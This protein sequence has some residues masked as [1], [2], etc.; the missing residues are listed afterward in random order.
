M[1]KKNAVWI[2][3]FVVLAVC[4]AL[5][6]FLLGQG[7]GAVSAQVYLDG[8]LLR[9]IDLSAVAAPYEF[10]VESELGTNTV[11]VENGAIAVISADCPD[12]VC[13]RQGFVSDDAI[14]I[15]C[16]PHRLVIQLTGDAHEN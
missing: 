6:F 2:T 12:Q 11:R 15:V 1:F 13:V 10:D 16:L 8:E 7:V 4:G 14:P 5:L 3:I 9:S